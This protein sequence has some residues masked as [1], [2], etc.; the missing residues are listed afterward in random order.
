[1]TP[2]H[3]GATLDHYR[4]ENLVARSGMASIYR[5]TDLRTGQPV[6]LKIPHPEMEADVVL[7]DRFQREQDIGVKLDHPSVMK[8][9][10]DDQRSR[11]YM[12]MEWV[13]G[14]SL[15]KILDEQHSLGHEL[16]IRLTLRILDALEYIHSWIE[17]QMRP[18]HV[19]VSLQYRVQRSD[20]LLAAALAKQKHPV[21]DGGIFLR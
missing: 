6:A 17:F 3:P 20:C 1:M 10:A 9:M 18:R 19:R 14:C 7:Y 4:I 11:I 2:L 12:V 21:V 15:R 16:S 13:E 5:G 8:V